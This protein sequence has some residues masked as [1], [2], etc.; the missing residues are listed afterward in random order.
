MPQKIKDAITKLPQYL[1]GG[2]N[3]K[4]KRFVLCAILLIAALVL[5]LTFLFGER[6]LIIMG[7]PAALKVWLEQYHAW[8]VAVFI[9]VRT[10]QTV[11]KFI[12][13]EPLEIGAG[14]AF[15]AFG[16]MAYCLLGSFLGSLIILFL[17]RRFGLRAVKVFV[18]E[19]KI[20]SL[21][22]LQNQKRVFVSLFILYLIP[23][24]PKDIITY[25]AGVTRLSN[26]KFLLIT[27]IARI[28]A[29]LTST[30]CG[31]QLV[32][33]DYRAA[34]LIFG[35]TVL[36]SVLGVLLYRKMEIQMKKND[37]PAQEESANRE[38]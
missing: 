14:F 28:P 32:S 19:E 2:K 20:N 25:L 10:T 36:V 4:Q 5:L 33:R 13:A 23:S 3:K 37:I 1:W 17:T 12:P 27:S 35:L 11:I 15:G 29:I 9:A 16:G 6:I 24:T 30:W 7:N 21:R 8:S 26:W 31:S 22:F 34:A 38:D 18:S